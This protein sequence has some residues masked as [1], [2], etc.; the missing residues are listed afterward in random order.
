[1]NSSPGRILGVTAGLLAA[2]ALFGAVA[3]LVAA[4][5][6]VTLTHG[7]AAAISWPILGWAAIIGAV[8][9]APLLPAASF[10]LLRRVPLGLAFAGTTAGT[11]VGGIAG[12]IAAVAMSGNAVLW[13][14]LAAVAGFFAA[15]V[16]LRL[17]FSAARESGHVRVPRGAD[18]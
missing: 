9:G 3:A 12:W 6:A 14:V 13:P 16:L 2:G 8:L 4:G 5:I 18:A 1:M 10:L 17:R 7:P 15:V 11:A